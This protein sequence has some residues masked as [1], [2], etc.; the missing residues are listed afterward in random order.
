MTRSLAKNFGGIARKAANLAASLCSMIFQYPEIGSG[1][2]QRRV[3]FPQTVCPSLKR[4]LTIDV[5]ARVTRIGRAEPQTR[6]VS[7]GRA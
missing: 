4:R 7:R 3:A 6:R 5:T 2:V 1:A